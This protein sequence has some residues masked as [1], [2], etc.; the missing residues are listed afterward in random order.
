M[1]YW[2]LNPECYFI[3]GIVCGAIYN[4]LTGQLIHLN[5]EETKMIAQCENNNPIVSSCNLLD[6]LTSMKWGT[7]F[8]SP[9]YIDKLRTGSAYDWLQ[10]FIRPPV[11]AA[12]LQITNRC[13][14]NCSFCGKLWCPICQKIPQKEE[15]PLIKWIPVIDQLT[16]MSC[17]NLY[18]TGGEASLYPE[19]EDLLHYTQKKFIRVTLVTNGL[20]PLIKTENIHTLVN[21]FPFEE[22][23]P[24]DL[25]SLMINIKGLSDFSL[26]FIGCNDEMKNRFSQYSPEKS[27]ITSINYESVIKKAI[28][29][30]YL[31]GFEIARKYEPCLYGKITITHGG[32]VIPCLKMMDHVSGNVTEQTI[33]SLIGDKLWAIWK[34]SKD[35]LTPCKECEFRY[36]CKSCLPIINSGTP[37]NYH[38]R[39]GTWIQS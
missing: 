29:M 36:A 3:P 11:F 34:T 31:S 21:I 18:L 4:L 7:F 30:Q 19:I 16:D 1:Q 24:A 39:E 6:T 20:L 35:V 28:P 15:L 22:Y 25:E 17:S 8:H 12:T 33:S 2:R 9:V 5:E 13:N 27:F 14:L 26:N 10:N 23:S 38:P 37:C 32:D